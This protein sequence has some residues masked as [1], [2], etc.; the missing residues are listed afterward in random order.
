MIYISLHNHFQISK[1]DIDSDHVYNDSFPNG[2]LGWEP[3]L[4][5][6][7][8]GSSY[9][10]FS[11]F[12]SSF[13]SLSL[14]LFL[15]FLIFC[16]FYPYHN[17][18]NMSDTIPSFWR[19]KKSLITRACEHP[20]VSSSI[21]LAILIIFESFHYCLLRM[22]AEDVHFINGFSFLLFFFHSLL[23]SRLRWRRGGKEI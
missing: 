23:L 8:Y 16:T 5:F 9:I 21:I 22:S 15:I 1:Y 13:F 17:D 4:S 20:Q 11:F 6:S 7:L 12:L 10:F 2:T 18:L 14:S 19:E 3:L